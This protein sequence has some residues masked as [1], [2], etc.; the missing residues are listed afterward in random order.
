MC[1]TPPHLRGRSPLERPVPVSPRAEAAARNNPSATTG[2]GL[3]CERRRRRRQRRRLGRRL[4]YNAHQHT[5]TRVHV[6]TL[7]C[8][9]VYVC[10]SIMCT[11]CTQTHIHT[12]TPSPP[13]PSPHYPLYARPHTGAH[14]HARTSHNCNAAACVYF[15]LCTHCKCLRERKYYISDANFFIFF[16]VPPKPFP[17]RFCYYNI[18]IHLG[19][20]LRY[21]GSVHNGV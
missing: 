19:I 18:V 15:T 7:R 1:T 10:V 21:T 17:F 12:R 5:H 20:L 4:L 16:Y 14:T 11:S 9:H 6:N 3:W 8:I 13:P 2:R